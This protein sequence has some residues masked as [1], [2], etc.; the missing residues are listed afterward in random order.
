VSDI[1]PQIPVWI[2]IVAAVALPFLIASLLAS[3]KL[4][5]VSE[6]TEKVLNVVSAISVLGFLIFLPWYESTRRHADRKDL[7]DNG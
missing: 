6:I 2:R 5:V 3:F 7:T 1:R 4:I